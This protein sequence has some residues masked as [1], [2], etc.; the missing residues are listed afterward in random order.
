MLFVILFVV[1]SLSSGR[2]SEETMG[3]EDTTAGSRV[4]SGRT[5]IQ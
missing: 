1:S 5:Y 4:K 3:G 2:D